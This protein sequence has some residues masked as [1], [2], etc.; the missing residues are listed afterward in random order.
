[1][2][3]LEVWLNMRDKSM[4]KSDVRE[5]QASSS[6]RS[7][8]RSS[9]GSERR[10]ATHRLV[11]RGS[12]RQASSSPDPLYNRALVLQCVMVPC[13]DS[14]TEAELAAMDPA[15][16]VKRRSG[17]RTFEMYRQERKGESSSVA[18][19]DLPKID[20]QYP[21]ESDWVPLSDGGS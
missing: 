6:S 16:T 11:L 3:A 9:L 1:M 21:N 15:T 18:P 14:A 17:T 20:G 10:N 12:Y 7:K 4:V 2:W 13:L 8:V 19:T 5:L